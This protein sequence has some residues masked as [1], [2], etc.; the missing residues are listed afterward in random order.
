MDTGA[1]RLRRR[2]AGLLGCAAVVAAF[3]CGATPTSPS[4]GTRPNFVIIVADDL[5]ADLFGPARRFSFLELPHLEA[6]AARS[7]VFDRACVTTSLCSPS[8][9]SILSGLYAHSHHVLG[10]ESADLPPSIVTFPMLLQQSGYRTAF[11]GKWHMD[12]STD[13]PRPGFDY[14]LSFRGQ[15]VYQDPVLNENG[16][17]G[18]VPGYI[19]DILTGYAVRWLAAQGGQPFALILAHKAVHEP[20][21]PAPRHAAAF[22]DASLPEPAS[23]RDSFAGK[24]GWQ[25]RYAACGGRADAFT[26]CPD[27]LPPAL[28]AWSWS[29][30]VRWRLDYL[31]TALALDESVGSVLAALQAGGLADSTYVLFLSDNGLFLGEHRL[32]DKRLAYEESIRV[33]LLIAG[34]QLAPRHTNALALNVDVAPTL[35]DLAGLSTPA[36]FEGRSLAPLLRGVSTRIR[37]AFLYEYF[38]DA[39]LPALP[40]IFALRNERYTYVSYPGSSD[41]ELYDLDRDPVELA[42]LSADPAAAGLRGQLR[43]QL[44]ELLPAGEP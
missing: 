28:P 11:I 36:R 8:R 20:F 10:N 3:G 39:T 25:R 32:G 41:D 31:R 33:P 5:A 38:A 43:R 21:Q 6:L 24:P 4:H 37:E 26:R 40:S 42:N 1:A 9:A 23:F 17:V 13:A 27:P 19:T 7:V 15:G 35:L 44:E 12:S 22:P 2:M 14:W 34:P 30:R 29:G 16:R 18:T